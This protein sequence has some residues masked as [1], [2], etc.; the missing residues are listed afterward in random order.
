MP[1]TIEFESDFGPILVEVEGTQSRGMKNVNREEKDAKPSKAE[2]R[3][4]EA[5]DTLRNVSD[6]LISKA[7]DIANTPDEFEVELGLTF[8][9]ET[10]VVIAK[11]STEGNLKVKMKW[12]KPVKKA[13]T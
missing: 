10:G 5:I 4:N 13:I 11:A 9:A 6:A 2:Q 7:H 12:N 1:K 8:K 3:F